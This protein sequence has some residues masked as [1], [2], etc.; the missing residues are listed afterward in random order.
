MMTLFPCDLIV[1]YST[2]KHDLSGSVVHGSDTEIACR[3]EFELRFSRFVMRLMAS[4]PDTDG[5]V[6][7]VIEISY[8]YNLTKFGIWY[9]FRV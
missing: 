7:G 8:S 5:D 9:A 3:S 6:S 4:E 2:S 1:V